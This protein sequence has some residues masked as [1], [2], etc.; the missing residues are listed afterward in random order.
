I[1]GSSLVVTFG[2]VF[3]TALVAVGVNPVLAAAMLPCICGVM[4]GI[5][6][7]LGLGMYAGMSLADSEFGKTFKNNLWWV[8]AQFIMVVV[9]LM[10]LLPILGL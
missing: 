2:P 3:I 8:G 7:P 5:T 1:P 9:V 10:G 4:C 6:P